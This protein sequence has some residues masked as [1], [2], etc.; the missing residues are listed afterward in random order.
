[1]NISPIDW[2]I[3]AGYI[4]FAL[5]L[6]IYF[7]KRAGKNIDEFFISGRNLPWWV[8]RHLYGRD[9]LR[10]RHTTCSY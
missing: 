3:V 7:S 5:G 2:A 4:L 8:G 6:G 10:C 1:M 9:N